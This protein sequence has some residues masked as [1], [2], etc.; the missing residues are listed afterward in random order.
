MRHVAKKITDLARKALSAED[1]P[2]TLMII[3]AGV[4]IAIFEYWGFLENKRVEV[5]YK[6][7]EQWE[8]DQY[9]AAFSRVAA[10]IRAFE[11]EAHDIIPDDLGEA[12]LAT[13]RLNYTQ[14]KI[15]EN[16]DGRLGQ[17]LDLLIYFFDKLSVCVDRGLCDGPLLAQFFEGHLERLWIYSTGFVASRRGTIDGYG[18]LAQAYRD[19][20]IQNNES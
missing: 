14:N 20:L 17:D 8:S 5:A 1:K 15:V 19:R 16:A 10:D 4:A 18:S 12:A 7:V 13:A 11:Q 2:I 9:Q 6:H 3:A